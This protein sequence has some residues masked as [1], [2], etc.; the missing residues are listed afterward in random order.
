MTFSQAIAAMHEGKAVRRSH[1]EREEEPLGRGLH[2]YLRVYDG[3]DELLQCWGFGSGKKKDY[4]TVDREEMHAEDWEIYQVDPRYA[5]RDGGCR[6][7]GCK[8]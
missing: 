4:A 8:A 1:W 6:A 5:R 7:F 3:G 2:L